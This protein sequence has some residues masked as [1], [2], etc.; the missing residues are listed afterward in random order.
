MRKILFFC[1]MVWA[2]SG[3][4][5]DEDFDDGIAKGKDSK[6][7]WIE[8]S[9]T[10]GQTK[11]VK[12]SFMIDYC[13]KVMFLYDENEEIIYPQNT[14]SIK[15]TLK[16][17]KEITGFPTDSLWLFQ[18]VKGKLSVYTTTPQIKIKTAEFFS[19]NNSD[20][21]PFSPDTLQYF[22][23]DN[24]KAVQAYKSYKTAKKMGGISS[25]TTA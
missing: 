11:M 21:M 19:K 6:K 18:I 15:T 3:V 25:I 1:G 23:A 12:S 5:Q 7:Y 24:P 4:A 16:N 20:L 14:Y 13:N 2:L 8:A 9:L 10:N 22:I 17:G